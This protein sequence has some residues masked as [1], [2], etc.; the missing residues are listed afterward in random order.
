MR[1]EDVQQQL[2]IDA[3]MHR[4]PVRVRT[5]LL[6][7]PNCRQALELYAEI[8]R[9]L[10]EQPAWQPPSGF[11]ERVSLLGLASLSEVP[12]RRPQSIFLRLLRPAVS[13]SPA[14]VLLGLLATAFSLLVLLF[15]ND[16][17]AGY[18]E[19]AAAFSRALLANGIQLSWITGILSLGF[20]A[21]ITRRALR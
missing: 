5:H 12:A 6:T 13:F 2:A 3:Q 14:P 10:R 9:R 21:W 7:C 8:D 19:L 18:P 17:L 16:F 4:L 11:A 20:T 15:F 1:C